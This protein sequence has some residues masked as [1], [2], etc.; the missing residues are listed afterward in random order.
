MK[1]YAATHADAGIR[2]KRNQDSV[3]VLEAETGQ[4]NILFASVCDGM[5]GLSRGETASAA[6]AEA[7]G[8]W[9]ENELPTLVRAAQKGGFPVRE[10]WSQWASLIERT[11]IRIEEFGKSNLIRLGTTAVGLL[12]AGR[13]YYTLNVG[14]SRVYLLMDGIVRLTK[15]QT[16]VQQELDAGR[17]T[18]EQSLTD[19]WRNVLLQCIGSGPSVRPAFG[20]G[21]AVSGQVFLVCS[22]GFRHVV[23]EEEMYSAFCPREMTGEAIMKQRLMAM[24]E[25]IKGR[26]EKDNISAA[27]IK[28]L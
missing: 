21:R 3:I 24:T 18:Y 6:M 9:F 23:T 2:K 4:G 7:F 5:G 25:C 20:R 11:S 8:S 22:D 19:P 16:Y 17:M 12:I 10:L 28:V 15:D 1:F 13:E 26:C 27:L 14:D